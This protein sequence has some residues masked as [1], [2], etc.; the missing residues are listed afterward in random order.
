VKHRKRDPARSVRKAGKILL[1]GVGAVLLA[2][3]VVKTSSVDAFVRRNPAAA[4]AF[5]ADHPRVRIAF[6]MAEFRLRNGRVSEPAMAGLVAA[7]AR[8]PLAEE[9]FAIEG[10]RAVAAGNEARGLKLL[11]EARR[12]DPR[13]RTARLILLDRYLRDKR[14]DK[15]GIEI[16]A[17]NRLIPRAGEVLVP[18]LAR[19]AR[20][21]RTG[22]ALIEVLAGEPSLQQAVLERLASSG[23]DAGLILRVASRTRAAA[24]RD[25]LPWQRVLLSRLVSSGDYPRAH[26]LWR[27]FAG[28][29]AAGVDKGLYDGA[30][31][32]LP[33]AAPF[34]WELVSGAAGVAERVGQPALQV[35]YYGRTDAELAKQLLM[36]R[37]GRYRLR[38]RVEGS[39]K[40]EGS[41]LE[42]VL[43]CPAGAAELL[44]IPLRDVDSSP[45]AMTGEFAVPGGC[46]AQW[47]RLRGVAGEVPDAQSATVSE[48]AIESARP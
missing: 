22:E 7:L 19:M 16:A 13:S 42:W 39:A 32:G 1:A 9:P 3:Q 4:A 43:S 10:V 28:M 47:L 6:A 37:P 41:R 35:E 48:M 36:L 20:E 8:A 26:Q 40:G 45:R 21:P 15:A 46:P 24:T 14:L 11:E 23:A 30:F 27:S 17:L 44:R 29:P 5:A 34:N 31:R 25:G 18:E 2:W 12:R 38:F 33:G